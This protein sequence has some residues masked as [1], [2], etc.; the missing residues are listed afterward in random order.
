MKVKITFFLFFVLLQFSAYAQITLPPGGSQKA[1]VSQWIGL[2]EVSI[3]YSSPAVHTAEGKDRTGHIW[4]EL[5]PYGLTD[6]GFGPSKKAPWRAGADENTVITLS[7][8]VKI[9]GKNLPAGSYGLHLIVEKDKPWTYIFSKNYTSWGSYFYD[10]KEDAL[11]V[12]VQAVDAPFAENL[13]YGFEARKLSSTVAFLQWENKKVPFTIEVDNIYDLYLAKIRNELRGEPGFS[14]ESWA[15]AA[16]FCVDHKINLEEALTWADAAIGAAYVGQENFNTLQT[17][18]NVLTALGRGAEADAVMDKAIRHRTASVEQIHGYG[19]RLL[20]EGNNKRALM[21]FQLNQQLHPEEKF[22][23]NVGLAR[24]YT[25]V[26]DKKSAIKYWEAALKNIPENQK[27]FLP[28]YQEEL[29]KVK[30]GK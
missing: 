19:K 26:G 27:Q 28:Q 29:N 18:A 30:Q 21:V 1:K 10:D 7:H 17:K 3:A 15:A 22:T 24:A 25:A 13:T 6:L 12:Q 9:N 4:G 5:V 11:R 20:T 2:V 16:Q 23:P 8:D 14:S